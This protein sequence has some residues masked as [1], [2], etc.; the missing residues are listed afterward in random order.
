MP[1]MQL[2][3]VGVTAWYPDEKGQRWACL[4]AGGQEDYIFGGDL[5]LTLRSLTK[6]LAGSTMPSLARAGGWWCALC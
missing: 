4:D 1:A 6:P 5:V 3:G 2:Q